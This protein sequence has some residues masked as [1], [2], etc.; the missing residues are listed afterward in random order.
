MRLTIVVPILVVSLSAC[1]GSG[2][3]GS[4]VPEPVEPEETHASPAPSSKDTFDPVGS[5]EIILSFGSH[6][7]SAVMEIEGSPGDYSGAI[8]PDGRPPAEFTSMVV[9]GSRLHIITTLPSSDGEATIDLVFEGDSFTG[10]IAV[11]GS[12]GTVSGRRR[13]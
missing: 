12:T 9:E 13:A 11:S 5:Y 8:T 10:T 7:V 6:E 4:A 3:Q 2:G 1:A